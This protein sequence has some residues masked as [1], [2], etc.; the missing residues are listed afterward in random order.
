M[1]KCLIIILAL[2]LCA[3]AVLMTG[4]EDKAVDVLEKVIYGDGDGY[5]APE[6]TEPKETTTKEKTIVRVTM[7]IKTDRKEVDGEMT[8]VEYPV[9]TGFN[10]IDTPVWS[11]NT[12]PVPIQDI[13]QFTEVGV[14]GDVFA[15]NNAGTVI[16]LFTEDGTT[17]WMNTEFGGHGATGAADPATGTVFMTSID[18]PALFVIDAKGKTVTSID[19][20]GEG[21]ADPEIKEIKDGKLI[22]NMMTGEK[23]V[24][25]DI[26][27]YSFTVE[28]GINNEST[29]H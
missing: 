27:D 1:K 23:T 16:A 21:L 20:F 25:V 17:A 4:C 9:I 24:L 12:R 5:E 15:F 10:T 11:M 7:E 6:T 14:V 26:S 13:V 2:I 18:G 8:D 3:S 28:E 29:D 22:I 19:S